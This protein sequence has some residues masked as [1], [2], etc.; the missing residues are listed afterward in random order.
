MISS[1]SQAVE[2]GW[3]GFEEKAVSVL[4]LACFRFPVLLV[5]VFHDLIS[6]AGCTS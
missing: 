6:G 1:S 5:F 2:H 3:E 4:E